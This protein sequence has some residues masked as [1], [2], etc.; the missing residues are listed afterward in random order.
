M[1]NLERKVTKS[2][3]ILSEYFPGGRSVLK[4]LN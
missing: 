4:I 1:L 2:W 3:M